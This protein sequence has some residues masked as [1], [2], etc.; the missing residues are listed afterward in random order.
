MQGHFLFILQSYII[1]TKGPNLF[2]YV[3][4][5]CVCLLPSLFPLFFCEGVHI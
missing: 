5:S 3:N 2:D 4:E 1:G